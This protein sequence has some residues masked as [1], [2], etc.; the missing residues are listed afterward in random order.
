MHSFACPFIHAP[1]VAWA[2]S[3]CAQHCHR[4][5]RTGELMPE[6]RARD[7]TRKRSPL[8]RASACNRVSARVAPGH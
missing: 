2:S 5:G 4:H 1:V 8:F 3:N 6:R 7:G